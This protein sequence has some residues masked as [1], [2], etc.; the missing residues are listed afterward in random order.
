M[1]EPSAYEQLFLELINR[2]RLDPTAEAQRTGVSLGTITAAQKQPLAFNLSINDAADAHSAWMLSSGTFSHTGSGGSSAGQRMES[3]GF[4]GIST[5]GENIAWNGTTGTLNTLSSVLGQHDGLFR[6]SGHR[7]NILNDSFKE[8]G[9]GSQSGSYSGYNALMTTQDFCRSGAGS[10]ITGV[11][12]NDSDSNAFYSVGEGRDGI[13][14][15]LLSGASLIGATATWSSGGYSMKTTATG[16]LT[17]RFSGGGLAQTIGAI[18][19]FAAYNAKIDLVNGN[20]IQS[21]VS[22]DLAF[23]TRN[24]RLLG[25]DDTDGTG[26]AG[27]NQLIGNKGSNQLD[28]LGGYDAIR[29]G[30]GND[31][32]DGGSGLDKLFGNQGNDTLNGGSGNDT[33]T[34]GSNADTFVFSGAFGKDKITDFQDG[35]DGIRFLNAGSSDFSDLTISGNGST[36]V[37]VAFGSNAIDVDGVNPITLSAADFQFLA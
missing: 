37:H 8:I 10:L 2:A 28:G 26:T 25:I 5:W 3:A 34:G 18:I 9:I 31:R 30:I 35:L 6:S 29:G 32:L 36:S 21:S 16:D 7:A 14:M 19:D 33:L 27:P 24:L 15:Q 12:Y 4:T 22:A 1:A 23:A 11:V 13:Q 17:V 20:T